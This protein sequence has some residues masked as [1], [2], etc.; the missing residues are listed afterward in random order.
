MKVADKLGD[1][2]PLG[3]VGNGNFV[4]GLVEAAHVPAHVRNK[5]LAVGLGLEKNSF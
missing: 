5:P 1:G 4:I 2:R 3:D